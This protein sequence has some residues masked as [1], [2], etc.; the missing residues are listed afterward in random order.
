MTALLQDPEAP[1][2]SV[3]E[4]AE[5]AGITVPEPTHEDGSL[6]YQM[7]DSEAKEER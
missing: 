6:P 4:I 5:S 1:K 2:R 3:R 7:Q